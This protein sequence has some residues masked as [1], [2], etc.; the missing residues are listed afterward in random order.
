MVAGTAV[1]FLGDAVAVGMV[2]DGVPTSP[3]GDSTAAD[4]LGF[5]A[6]LA[7]VEDL[8]IHAGSESKLAKAIFS[9]AVKSAAN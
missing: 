4:S 7:A 2:D 3:S 8:P 5:L 1:T 9:G 6:A